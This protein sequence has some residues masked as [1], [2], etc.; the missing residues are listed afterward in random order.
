MG[1]A[2]IVVQ[3]EHG[4][5]VGLFTT[6]MHW[7][8]GKTYVGSRNDFIFLIS[9]EGTFTSFSSANSKKENT[10]LC[11]REFITVGEGPAFR[12]SAD[13]Q[14]ASSSACPVFASPP[15]WKDVTSVVEVEV[16]LIE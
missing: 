8:I 16:F 14:S 5:R 6:E 15:L 7:R 11:E 3:T 12:L 1:N 13:L 10:L 9:P 4:L 2:L